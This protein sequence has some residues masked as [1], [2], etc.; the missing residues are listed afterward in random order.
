[1]AFIDD[2][3]SPELFTFIKPSQLEVTYGGTAPKVTK[4]WPPTMPEQVEPIENGLDFVKLEDYDQFLSEYPSLTPM[5][6]SLRPEIFE[7]P[8]NITSRVGAQ[9]K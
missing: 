5:P 6:S 1:M 2:L 3:T 4:F 7:C 8:P 9:Q